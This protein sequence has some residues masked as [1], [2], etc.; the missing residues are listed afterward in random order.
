[1]K[2]NLLKTQIHH[3]L[4]AMIWFCVSWQPAYAQS[5]AP[6]YIAA[7]QAEERTKNLSSTISQLLPDREVHLIDVSEGFIPPEP[8]VF[9]A[10]GSK[11]L[12]T[13]LEN[14]LT[15]PII[16]VFV[17][18][19]A[20]EQIKIRFGNIPDSVRVI[21]SDPS[22]RQQL[23]LIYTIFGRR[24]HVGILLS[25]KT[26][27]MRQELES[28]ARQMDMPPPIIKNFEPD[29]S[30][31]QNF[32]KL[33]KNFKTDIILALPDASIYNEET[34]RGIIRQKFRGRRLPVIGYSRQLVKIGV[35][36]TAFSEIK[37]IAKQTTELLDKIEN[38][39][40]HQQTSY[41]KYTNVETNQRVANLFGF[42]LRSQKTILAI[43]KSILA[44]LNNENI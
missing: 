13:L 26:N 6:I 18:R 20:Y 23:S 12:V 37:D 29:K 7:S 32:F 43:Y 42:R 9:I 1:M 21:F 10:S 36:A 28:I 24:T 5:G 38:N 27:F 22:P 35:L 2:K 11:A 41:L 8:A 17:S 44:G 3:A 39:K 30:V 14:E 33:H 19:I 31:Y 15:N 34:W 40:H 25:D 4:L 16:A